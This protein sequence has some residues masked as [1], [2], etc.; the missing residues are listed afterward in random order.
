MF[1]HEHEIEMTRRYRKDHDLMPIK[2]EQLINIFSSL[3]EEDIHQ[4]LYP[5]D[6]SLNRV[7]VRGIYLGKYDR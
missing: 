4:Y 7:G 6:F 2:P 3:N 5:D 1:S